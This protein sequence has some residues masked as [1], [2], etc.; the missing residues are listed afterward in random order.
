MVKKTTAPEKK[1]EKTQ[2]KESQIVFTVGKRK[3]AVARARLKPGKGVIKINS[4]P[5]ELIQPEFLR[6]R[7]EEPLMLVGDAWKNFDINV[8][9]KGG[10][11]MGQADATRQA[12]ARCLCEV[13]GPEVKKTFISYDRN[14]LVYD[15]RRTEP[16][17]P[18][19]SSW[20]PR[21]YK[22]RSKR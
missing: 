20:G 8:N 21:R 13:L 9:V 18:P 16:H 7:I 19:H 1:G 14:L 4:V 22:Q 15:P 6:M 10:G 17:K 5:L 3:R 11:I 12:I 2:T